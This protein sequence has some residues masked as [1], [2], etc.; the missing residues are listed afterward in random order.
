[1]FLLLFGDFRGIGSSLISLRLRIGYRWLQLPNDKGYRRDLLIHQAC[2]LS[3][4]LKRCVSIHAK[5]GGHNRIEAIN[6]AREMD[7]L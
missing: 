4:H 2:C 7:L 6:T 1:M 5:L 3:L